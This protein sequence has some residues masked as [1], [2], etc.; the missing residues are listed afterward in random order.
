MFRVSAGLLEFGGRVRAYDPPSEADIG[1]G[2]VGL[3]DREGVGVAPGAG[4]V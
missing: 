4:A 3:R 1:E 2:H